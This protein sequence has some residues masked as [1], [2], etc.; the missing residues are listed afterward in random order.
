M[1][2]EELVN[3]ADVRWAIDP[4]LDEKTLPDAVIESAVVV[5][6]AINELL[7]LNPAA[8]ADADDEAKQVH[9]QVA[10]NLLV[11]AV[12]LPRLPDVTKEEYNDGGGF[13]KQAIDKVARAAELRLQAGAE[14]APLVLNPLPPSTG[15]TLPRSSTAR[16]VAV[17]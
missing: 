8:A 10:L 15:L 5:Y 4:T 1:N 7:V 13:T 2:L 6:P 14:I 17:W 3:S 12:L 11:A 16:V 9:I